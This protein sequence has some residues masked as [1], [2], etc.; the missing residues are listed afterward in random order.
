MGF[1]TEAAE[2]SAQ[3]AIRRTHVPEWM[4]L[5]PVAG[6]ALIGMILLVAWVLPSGGTPD[7]AITGPAGITYIPS[8]GDEET[9]AAPQENPGTPQ[10]TVP[11]TNPGPTPTTVA[12]SRV[13]VE[14]T[15]GGTVEIDSAALAVAK[16]A[17][18][19]IWTANWD[20]VPVD[21]TP[22]SDEASA[23]PDAKLASIKVRTVDPTLISFV[24]DIDVDGDGDAD[25]TTAVNVQSQGGKWVF[26]VVGL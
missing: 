9:P 6:L 10:E 15:G 14:K 12:A 21:G 19:A 7:G 1:L 8:N 25:S 2:K 16:A 26:I 22:T 23:Y 17:A 13:S 20:G 4:A 5:A 11:A 3:K 18:V 24:A